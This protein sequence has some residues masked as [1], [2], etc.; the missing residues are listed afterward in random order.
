MSG[1]AALWESERVYTRPSMA[2]IER[3]PRNGLTAV[4][5]FSGAGG[6]SL[7]LKMAGWTIPYAVE[8][9]EA[10]ADSYEAN[11]PEAYVDRRDIREVEPE[12][13]LDRIGLRPG[14]LD[15]LEGSPPCASFS[16]AGAR[17][18]HWGEVKKYSETRQ[19]T[20][21]LFFEWLRILRGLRPRA[22][23]A[24][25]VPGMVIGSALE[26]YAHRVV[27]EMAE[28]GYLTTAKLVYASW[29]GA[30]TARRRLIFVGIRRDI[31]ASFDFPPPTVDPP[32]TLREALDAIDPE[33]P[34]HA[35]YVKTA[36]ME[37]F[38]IGRTWHAIIDARK[39]GSVFDPYLGECRRCGQPVYRHE[40]AEQL[41][42]HGR[43]AA[44]F[45]DDGEKA[46]LTKLYYAM[47]VP[48]LDKPCPTIM[49]AG[50]QN[51]HAGGVTHPTECRKFSVAEMK[52]IFG[53]PA[54]FRLTGTREQ[55]Y[56]RMGRSVAP[57]MYEAIG[58]RLAEVLACA[59]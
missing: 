28:A 26:E 59:D 39:K 21:D 11:F 31:A 45:C 3:R 25:N 30:P 42:G 49:A 5:T 43:D 23:L 46:E 17:E 10:A 20:D 2:E 38:A 44:I 6:S 8:F 4:G 13:I 50:A 14:E 52:S 19:R 15:L 57:P 54:D 41:E 29:W 36:S 32:F 55:R 24:E 53:F 56:E 58:G 16:A 33:D 48:E 47:I 37:G 18:R 34:D 40:G 1:Q 27:E 7:G 12:G 9:I 22:F 51:A 35:E